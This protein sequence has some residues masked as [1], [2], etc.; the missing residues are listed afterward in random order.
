MK[1]KRILYCSLAYRSYFFTS[2][3]FESLDHGSFAI[4]PRQLLG[5][6]VNDLVDQIVDCI[7]LA[8]GGVLNLRVSHCTVH[9]D[10]AVDFDHLEDA[11][12]DCDGMLLIVP[13]E[14]DGIVGASGTHL[15]FFTV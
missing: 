9:V 14:D 5:G 6:V 15:N 2:F 8:F 12:V 3:F 13:A 10:L 4:L 11:Q 7:E 1:T